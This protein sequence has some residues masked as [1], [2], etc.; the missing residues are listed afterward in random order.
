MHLINK[1]TGEAGEQGSPAWK[2]LR[3]T[4]VTASDLPIILGKSPY[5]TP[6]LLWQRKVGFAP[7]Q[8]T[9]PHM[10]RG[11]DLEPLVRDMVNRDMGTNFQ[12]C[13]VKSQESDWAIAS[14]D[15]FDDSTGEILEIKCGSKASHE[16]AASGKV[17]EKY[18]AQLQ[19]QMFC[20]GS[21]TCYYVSYY[22]GEYVMIKVPYEEC[23]IRH[24]VIHAARDFYK[25]ILEMREP[26]SSEKDIEKDLV[27]IDDPEFLEIIPEWKQ[28]NKM[29]TFYEEQEKSLK[30]RLV[31]FT[32]DGDCTGG[33][34][35]LKRVQRSGSI[36]WD[37]L[38]KE[39]RAEYPCVDTFNPEEYRKK[40]IGYWKISQE[41]DDAG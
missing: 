22:D 24:G 8:E 32:D 30:D 31:E 33:G 27:V 19:W 3:S 1:I 36:D 26:A 16:E 18:M 41:K 21:I 20:S 7:E 14:L 13:V 39:V 2:A 34:I 10:R 6:L 12:P 28:A 38:W 40:Q 25:C 11:T 4:K 5:C 23:F 37:K 35:T 17:P 15:G 29:R 9:L